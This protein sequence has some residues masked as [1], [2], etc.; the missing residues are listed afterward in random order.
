MDSHGEYSPLD[1]SRLLRSGLDGGGS[2]GGIGISSAGACGNLATSVSEVIGRAA[3]PTTFSL[4]QYH[5][6]FGL[7]SAVPGE[8]MYPWMYCCCSL[9]LSLSL[10]DLT[11]VLLEITK[12][13]IQTPFFIN[14]HNSFQ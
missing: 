4:A 6:R 13:F 7:P 11:N 2:G 1:R 5:N 3:T 10:Q 8:Y 9:S 12:T 14:H